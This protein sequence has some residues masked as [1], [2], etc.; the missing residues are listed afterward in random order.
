MQLPSPA[1]LNLFL[2]ITGRRQ[3][4]YHE[5]QT[6]FQ[7]VDLCDTLTFSLTSNNRIE[8]APE[9]KSLPQQENLVY[10]AAE[11]LVD[12]CPAP[13]WSNRLSVRLR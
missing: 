1:K 11:I 5:L 12:A 10:K 9:I 4:G 8:I 2:H 7:F 3:D 13:K 6:I